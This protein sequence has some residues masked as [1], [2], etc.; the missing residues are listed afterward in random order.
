LF[1]FFLAQSPQS[2]FYRCV[3]VAFL[4]SQSYLNKTWRTW[5]KPFACLAVKQTKTWERVY[6]SNCIKKS[7]H[8][9]RLFYECYQS[10]S[11]KQSIFIVVEQYLIIRHKKRCNFL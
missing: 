1:S 2:F 5:R 6:K 7:V 9:N 3:Y 10:L 11:S 4:S 8:A